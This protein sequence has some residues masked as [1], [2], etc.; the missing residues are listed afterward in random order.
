MPGGR[1]VYVTCSIF[2]AENDAIV[3]RFL[4]DNAGF[5]PVGSGAVWPAVLDTDPPPGVIDG[6]FV[7]LLP[8]IASTDGFFVAIMERAGP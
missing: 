7:R 2:P 8:H 3:K 6:D 5:R 4:Q 1:L